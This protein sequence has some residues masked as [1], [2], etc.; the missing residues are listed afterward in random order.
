MSSLLDKIEAITAKSKAGSSVLIPPVIL[1]KTSLDP[2]WKPALFSK[3]ASNIFSLL[4]SKP[5]ELLCG[6]P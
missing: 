5:V 3:T 1:R 2:S 4:E 6:V